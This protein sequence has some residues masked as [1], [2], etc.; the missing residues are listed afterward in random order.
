MDV[1]AR[2]A[3][4]L[5]TTLTLSG[6]LYDWAALRRDGSVEASADRPLPRDSAS[7]DA[8]EID[9]EFTDASAGD[10]A[11]TEAGERDA[12]GIDAS[13]G[14]APR[15]ATMDAR[16]AGAD[17]SDVGTADAAGDGGDA[18]TDA[19]DAGT[20]ASDAGT[21]ASDAGTDASDAG[22]D[23]RDALGPGADG[24]G[25]CSGSIVIN[26]VQ[27]TGSTS[28]TDE[29]VELQNNGAC[30]ANL[31]GWQLLYVTGSGT[32]PQS[33]FTFSMTDRLAPGAQM[34][35]AGLSHQPAAMLRRIPMGRGI[36]TAAGVAIVDRTM[37][38]V[39]SVAFGT[40]SPTHP[41]L[42]PE[43]GAPAPAPGVAQ[44]TARTPSGRDTNVNAVDFTVGMPSPGAPN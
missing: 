5:F 2:R 42:E 24:G 15:D 25:G 21:D 10:A 39:D 20:D 35:V 37:R 6:C 4:L 36:A 22:A 28:G 40:V 14:A 12:G 18:G 3:A 33:L 44:S 13:D 8:T 1:T 29:F 17:A 27:H 26:E 38:R 34:L 19:R 7:E 43:G 16:D 30:E 23:A 11:G 31:D 41:Y 9:G 32:T